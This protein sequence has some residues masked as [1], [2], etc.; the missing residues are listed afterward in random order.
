[1]MTPEQNEFLTRVGPGSPA[2]DMLRRY[3][4]PVA[5]ACEL[6][7]EKPIKGV[8]ILGEDLIV[9]RMPPAAGGNLNRDTDL[10][11]S[12]ARIGGRRSYTATS[13]RRA[14]AARITVGNSTLRDVAWSNQPS[15]RTA[16]T[17]TVS[18]TQPIRSKNW[19]ACCSPIWVRRLRR[20]C[21][22]GTCWRA[23]TAGGG[24]W[25]NQ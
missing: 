21:R 13:I 5:A 25:L 23:K 7:A 22:A 2:G 15:L 3:W 14:S 4:H 11:P 20:C 8:R 12:I 9:F 24:A 18:S 10:S 16:P 6:T 19:P 17:R 1:M